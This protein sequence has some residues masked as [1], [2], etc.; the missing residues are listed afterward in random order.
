MIHT[1]GTIWKGGGCNEQ[2]LLASCYFHSMQLAVE[3][4]IRSV[5]FPFISTGI[6]RFPVELAAKIAV[7]TV[8]RFLEYNSNYFD[9]V[10]WV[11]F[12][13]ATERAYETEIDKLYEN[14]N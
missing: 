6:Y 12:D 13:S 2:E 5:A 10:E 11:L 1:V 8:N 7:K 9:L 3:H 14:S 4:G